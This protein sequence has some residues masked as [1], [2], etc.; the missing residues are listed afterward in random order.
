M[1]HRLIENL[2]IAFWNTTIPALIGMR[3]L[4][5]VFSHGRTAFFA[6]V[7]ERV[8]LQSVVWSVIGLIFGVLLGILNAG[9]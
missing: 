9:L 3:W 4:R 1:D 7:P 6:I 2:E 8:L 5:Q